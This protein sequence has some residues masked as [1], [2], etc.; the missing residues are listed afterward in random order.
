MKWIVYL[1]TS[2]FVYLAIVSLIWKKK[3][4]SYHFHISTL[5][6][7]LMKSGYFE[8]FV[9]KYRY[10]LAICIVKRSV[11]KIR[12]MLNTCALLRVTIINFVWWNKFI[13]I[14]KWTNIYLKS[15]ENNSKPTR[16]FICT[17]D[18]INWIDHLLSAS[19]WSEVII[20]FKNNWHGLM[21]CLFI[22]RKFCKEMCNCEY[23]DYEYL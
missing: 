13:I 21:M 9:Q 17:I 8:F 4:I 5:L 19:C 15:E 14:N 23:Y 12:M 16:Y 7:Y 11:R 1:P 6:N 2:Q 22:G 3:D 20:R 18:I 10:D